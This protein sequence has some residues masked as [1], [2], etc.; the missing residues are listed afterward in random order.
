MSVS[1]IPSGNSQFAA[2]GASDQDKGKIEEKI[3]EI[4]KK[5]Q[6]EEQSF[7]SAK[8]KK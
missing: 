7:D 3:K 5:I 4:K 8:E 2:A 1:A 6:Q